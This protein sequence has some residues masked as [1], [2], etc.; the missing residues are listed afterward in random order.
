MQPAYALAVHVVRS[1]FIVGVHV[2]CYVRVKPLPHQTGCCFY[3]A[4]MR[5]LG[6]VGKN[7]NGLF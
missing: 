3:Y 7:V 5:P 1:Y 2:H 4:Y 6:L